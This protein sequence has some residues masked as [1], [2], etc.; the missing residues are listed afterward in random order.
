MLVFPVI[1]VLELIPTDAVILPNVFNPVLPLPLTTK[2]PVILGLCSQTV[3]EKAYSV[4]SDKAVFYLKHKSFF[5]YLGP[6]RYGSTGLPWGH[7]RMTEAEYDEYILNEFP[8]RAHSI[9]KFFYEI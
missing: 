6:H 5:S 1:N 4:S 7:L 2:D 8:D 9:K 3:F